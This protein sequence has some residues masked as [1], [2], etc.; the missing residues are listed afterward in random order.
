MSLPKSF[1]RHAFWLPLAAVLVACASSH[2][3][4]ALELYAIDRA[5]VGQRAL[6]MA[7]P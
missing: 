6:R 5:L 2:R 4:A 1:Q 7:R 3:A